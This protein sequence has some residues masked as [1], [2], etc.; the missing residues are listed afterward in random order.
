MEKLG[1][2]LRTACY[3]QSQSL[4]KIQWIVRR[5]P[6]AVKSKDEDGYLPLHYA[7][8][9]QAPVKVVDYLVQQYPDAIKVEAQ[10]AEIPLHCAVS[11]THLT[12]PT[13]CSV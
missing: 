11:Y 4:K 8:G 9:R 1:E 5:Y 6:E 12:L 7:C 2:A 13:I 3:E 10:D